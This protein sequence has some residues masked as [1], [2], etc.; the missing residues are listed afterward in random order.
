MGLPP[1]SRP[2]PHLKRCLLTFCADLGSVPNPHGEEEGG[3]GIWGAVWVLAALLSLAS[4]QHRPAGLT[5]GK[6]G[7]GPPGETTVTVSGLGSLLPPLSTHN[8]FST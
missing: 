5:R 8:L 3:P 1:A 6:W 2:P 7:P 4:H